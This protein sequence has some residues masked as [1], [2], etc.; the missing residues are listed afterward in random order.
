MSKRTIFLSGG[1]VAIAALA[2]TV[3]AVQIMSSTPA[4]LKAPVAGAQPATGSV[5]QAPAAAPAATVSVSGIGRASAAPDIARLTIGVESLQPNAGKAVSEVNT[6]QAAIIAKLKALGIADKDI[7]TT[8]FSVSIDRGTQPRPGADGPV[9]Y[10]ASNTATVVVRKLDQL[11]A[12]IDAA[13]EAGAN[14]I[15]GVSLSLSDNTAIVG[16]ARNKAVAD[17]RAKAE[18]LAKAAGVKLGRIIS[19]SEAGAAS[20]VPVFAAAEA[21][22]A[23]GAIET[24]ELTV[25]AQVNIVFAIE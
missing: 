2:I 25:S 19:I 12:V 18:S 11:G 20:P 9:S 5:L 13:T 14:T 10:R 23:G 16:D 4:S 7:Q 1:I 17:A 6:K 15:Y 22:G 24:G 21:R 3:L 8:N